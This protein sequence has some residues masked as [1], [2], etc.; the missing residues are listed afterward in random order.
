ME[1]NNINVCEEK[2]R[3][4]QSDSTTISLCQQKKRKNINLMSLVFFITTILIPIYT[5]S[6]PLFL[7]SKIPNKTW[8]MKEILKAV[9][10]K[11]EILVHVVCHSHNDPGWRVTYD[12][13]YTGNNYLRSSVK[14]I[15]DSMVIS[16]TNNTERKFLFAETIFFKRWYNS[17]TEDIKSKVKNFI[18]NGRLDIV[19]GGWVMHDEA[20][21]Y[22]KHLIDNMQIGLKFLKE[23][24]NL[25]P[26]IG[27]F[28]DDFGHSAATAHLI[29]QMGFDKIV[30]TRLNHQEK[31]YRIVNKN[32]EFYYDAF[33]LNQSIFTHISFDHYN[34]VTKPDYFSG[35]LKLKIDDKKL[36][37]I[38]ENFYDLMMERREGYRH[39]NVLFYYG[40]DFTFQEENINYENIEMLMNYV[41]KNMKGKMKM[42][43][44]T[45]TQYFDYVMKSGAKFE[46]YKNNDF[47]TYANDPK[48]YWSGF[49]TS[50]A[51]LKG[52]IK[53]LGIY[54]NVA[55]RM[56]FEVFYDSKKA[57][58]Y[59]SEL[60]KISE[61]VYSTRET[62]ALVQHH[63]AVTGTSNERTSKDYEDMI[64]KNITKLKEQINS[65]VNILNNNDSLKHISCGYEEKLHIYGINKKNK[66]IIIN[67]NLNEKRLFNYRLSEYKK[68]NNTSYEYEIQQ[69]ENI[70]Y[71]N[72]ISFNDGNFSYSSLQFISKLDKNNLIIPTIIT[73]TDKNIPKTYFSDLKENS[74]IKINNGELLFNYKELKF[75][76]TKKKL[77]FSL[78]HGYYT[79]KASYPCDGAYLF[80]PNEDQVIY[81]NQTDDKKSFYQQ[82]DNFTSIIIR[83]PNSYLIIIIQNENLNIYTESIFDPYPDRP[84]KGFNYIL[85][86]D[87]NI[88]NINKKYLKPEIYTDS[89]G[90]N[91][92]QR[93]RDTHP[94]FEYKITQNVS[95]NFYPITSVVSVN[96]VDNSKNKISIFS[97]RAQAAG[98]LEKGQIQIIC[99]RFTV[100][101]DDKGISSR[102][103]EYSSTK[104]FFPV[105]HFISF[106]NKN[107][108]G[109]F[110]SVPLIAKVN[111]LDNK[112]VLSKVGNLI[113][114][115]DSIDADFNIN[116]YGEVFVQ[117][118]NV[119]CDYFSEYGKENEKFKFNCDEFK[120][121]E[122]NLNG[123][124]ESGKEIQKGEEICLMKQKFKLFLLTNK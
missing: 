18:K 121:K 68:N 99:H 60:E 108:F 103:Y 42:I 50:R 72:S 92:L 81:Y 65:L 2:N 12:E 119:Y 58:K 90:I 31:L 37:R 64:N 32:L 55:N 117:I 53:Q 59:K 118:G 30:L 22:Y 100:N 85:I 20:T 114:G 56:I 36:K 89:Q 82:N 78:R 87:S 105:K 41:N 8:N 62:L 71:G 69:G 6:Y 104:R 93:I 88:N 116:K 110:N 94:T 10:P 86:L 70:I 4:N 52:I 73:R 124:D 47:F 83:F 95:S 80:S 115:G 15:L 48:S 28:I 101:D 74:T 75:T 19:N 123:V 13:Y 106:D 25:T 122:F 79:S 49:F 1:E 39:N 7:I 43:Y 112:I 91:M 109:Y 102:L 120:I 45:P 77:E 14:Q 40:D 29:N 27:W 38:A 67:P 17:Q 34:E 21:T 16:L 3:L 26:K 33:G 66:F 54:I 96:D 97:D 11:E 113:E 98:V 111:N 61:N 9:F 107:N 5:F 35:D 44:S 46:V 51:Y 23:E 57:E 76:N 84:K 63:D 24:F